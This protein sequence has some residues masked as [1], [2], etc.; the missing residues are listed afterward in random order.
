M[1][2]V[3]KQHDEKLHLECA[4]RPA[5]ASPAAGYMALHVK[6]QEHVINTALNLI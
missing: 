1:R 6:E 5:S 3:I 4:S 2:L